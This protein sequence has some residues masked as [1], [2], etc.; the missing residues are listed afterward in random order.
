M[1]YQQF[2]EITASDRWKALEASGARVQRP[3]WASTGTK[4]PAYSDVLYVET[5]IGPQ[6]V[7]TMPDQTIDAFMDHGTVARTVDADLD[8]AR[9]ALADVAAAGV[10][11][12]DVTRQLEIDGVKSFSESF[13]SLLRTIEERVGPVG[14]RGAA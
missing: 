5:L 6:C 8:E 7:N 9:Q 3:L 1:A 4:N 14:E 10:S 13:D 11:L 2:L 12:D